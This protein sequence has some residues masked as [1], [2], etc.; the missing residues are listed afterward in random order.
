MMGSRTGFDKGILVAIFLIAAISLLSV[1][2]S[3]NQAG[4]AFKSDFLMK[5]VSWLCLGIVFLILVSNFNYR[6]FF[7]FGWLLYI[8]S[9]LL[10]ILVILIAEPRSG[11]Q[12]WLE[13]LGLNFQPSELARLAVILVLARHLSKRGQLNNY[14][15]SSLRFDSQIFRDL[16]V[17]VFIVALPMFLIFKQP[18]LGA[19]LSL[20]PVLLA[21]LFMSG[22]NTKYIISL[23]VTGGLF[24]P[25]FWHFLKAY[26]K[27]RILV[28]LN[29]NLDPLGAGYTI[30]QSKIAIGS[31]GFFG[32]GWLAGTQN[33]LNFLPER[34]TDFIF[35]VVGE[36]FGFLGA[37]LLIILYYFIILRVIKI[38]QATNDAFAQLVIIGIVSLLTF[39]ICVNI[40]MTL[41]VMPVVGLT[42]PLLSY[43]GSSL[44]MTFI[45]FGIILN[46]NKKRVVF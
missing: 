30:I 12:R 22:I 42:L 7:D 15:N 35:S 8:V 41:G 32:K 31:G 19:S 28:F 6:R 13:I 4:I 46:I 1:Y 24:L 44:I 10:L 23:I 40:A 17:P 34:H 2:S 16:I 21:M 11:A 43:G 9:I 33:Q 14:G 27:A 18:H 29:P 26:Q 3:T 38:C 45:L 36:E 20:L 37:C 25:F 5:Q 39:Q